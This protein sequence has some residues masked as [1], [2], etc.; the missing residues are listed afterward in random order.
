MWGLL[1]LLAVPLVVMLAIRHMNPDHPHRF[2]FK[3][4]LLLEAVMSLLLVVGFMGAREAAMADQEYWSGRITKKDQGTQKCCHCRNVCK[5]R[6]SKGACTRS[7]E[8]CSHSRDHWW[9]LRVSTGDEISVERCSGSSRDP[10]AWTNAYVG[11]PAVVGHHFRN[12]LLADPESIMVRSSTATGTAPP[13]PS[14]Y[15]LYKVNRAMSAGHTK[16]DPVLWSRKL[17]EIM[18]DLGGRKQVNVNVIATNNPDPTWAQVVER[19]WLYGKLNDATFV[20]GAPG[21]EK[22]EW[23]A[24]VTLPTGNE[25]LRVVGRDA[26]IGT[27]LSDPDATLAT[28]QR[29]V[30]DEWKW[31]GLDSLEY[32]ADAAQPPTWLLVM[33]YVVGILGAVG[34]SFYMLE[35]D[36]FGDEGY[37]SYS[38]RNRYY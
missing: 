4:F 31:S 14:I 37:S 27:S 7:V 26:L 10:A 16:M 3:E 12:Y 18:A 35:K 9:S 22:V 1:P 32:L 19:D 25:K 21:G 2:T 30:T 38:R 6:N 36:V 33:L 8:E 20:L 34:G 23:A 15:G 13:Y 17:D 11:E 24:V 29:V 5:S 28:I